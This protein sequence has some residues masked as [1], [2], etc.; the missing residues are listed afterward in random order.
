MSGNQLTI[1]PTQP[2]IGTFTI[3]ATVSDDGVTA[4]RTF[5]L[6]LTNTAPTLAA[7]APQTMAHNQT[8]L[9]IA[10]SAADADNDMLTVQAVAQTPSA[11]AYELDQEYAF[12][13]SNATYYYNLTGHNEKWFIGRNNQWYALLPN[14]NLYHWATSIATTFTAANLVATLPTAFYTQPLLL[15]NANPPVTPALTFSVV[16]NQLTIQRPASL[17]GVFFV[18]VTVSDGWLTAEQ[19]VEVVLN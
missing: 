4:S 19:T 18:N 13:P 7:I 10:L 2:I 9:T 14:G 17:I 15:V 6:T 5:T 16:G 3:T 8:S 12:E 1:H 11:T